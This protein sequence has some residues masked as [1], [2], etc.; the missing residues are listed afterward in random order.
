[1]MDGKFKASQL[2]QLKLEVRSSHR[3]LMVMNPTSIHEDTGSIL[4]L[5]QWVK[6]FG[7]AMSCG[8][9]RRCSLD[10]ALLWLCQQLQLRLDP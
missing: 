7:F 3:G 4:V 6:G 1:M 2:A 9:G 10:L 8:K 5:A